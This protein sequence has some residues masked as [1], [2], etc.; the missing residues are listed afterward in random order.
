LAVT[1]PL[2]RKASLTERPVSTGRE[3]LTGRRRGMGA[4]LA[5]AGPAVVASTAHNPGGFA[6][7]IEAGVLGSDAG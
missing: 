3:V 5:F 4:Y 1:K 7:D 6:S 2:V